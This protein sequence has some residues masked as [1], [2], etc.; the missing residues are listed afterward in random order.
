M[1]KKDREYFKKLIEEKKEKVIKN[2]DY[3]RTVVLDSTTK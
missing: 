2:L 1:N 3:L